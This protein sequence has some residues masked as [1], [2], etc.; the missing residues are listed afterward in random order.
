M[1]GIVDYGA[2]NLNSVKKAFNFLQKKSLILKHAEEFKDINRLV[3]PGVGSFGHALKKIREK[4]F[5]EPIKKWIESNQSFL[6]ICLGMQLL[7]ERSEESEGEE[8]LSFFKGYCRRFTQFKVPQIGWNNILF[9]QETAFLHG[10]KNK[11]YFYFNH[12]YYVVPKEKE[13]VLAQSHYGID[14]P[15]IV[16]KGNVYGVQFHPEKSGQKGINLLKNW[17]ERC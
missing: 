10:I 13:V 5:F 14:F 16:R 15:C 17:E 2:G 3:L 4:D 8:G 6:G 7:F 12:S 11:E 9:D 1:I